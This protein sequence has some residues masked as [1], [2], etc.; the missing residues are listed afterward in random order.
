MAPFALSFG[1]PRCREG[2]ARCDVGGSTLPFPDVGVDS[3][4]HGAGGD[5]AGG[6]H[7]FAVHGQDALDVHGGLAV[8]GEGEVLRG[9]RRRHGRDGLERR[10]DDGA[11]SSLEGDGEFGDAGG[12]V[13]GGPGDGDGLG[14]SGDYG[15]ELR[16]GCLLWSGGG[17]GVELPGSAEVGGGEHGSDEC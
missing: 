6:G 8:D 4:L 11:G 2:V 9:G 12:A 5:G 14:V 15:D 3:G 1:G 16:F 7:G 13:G 10:F 17:L